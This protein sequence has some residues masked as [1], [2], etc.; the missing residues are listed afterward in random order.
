MVRPR[1]STPSNSRRTP[2]RRRRSRIAVT[3]AVPVICLSAA[4]VLAA[5]AGPPSVLHVGQIAQQDLP[6]LPGSERDTLVEPDV[7]VSPLNSHIAVA[8]AHDGRY[9]DGGAVG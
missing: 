4:P 1:S 8:V 5:S 6:R 9:P 2:T 3:A 7:A